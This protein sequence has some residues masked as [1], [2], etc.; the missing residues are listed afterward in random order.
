MPGFDHMDWYKLLF[1]YGV[2][3]NGDPDPDDPDNEL[4]PTLV[5]S[6][7][8]PAA[9]HAVEKVRTIGFF[10]ISCARRLIY[11]TQTSFKKLQYLRV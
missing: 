9:Q 7:A 8:L 5:E 2:G 6:I 1:D 4:V 10:Q 3:D 11:T